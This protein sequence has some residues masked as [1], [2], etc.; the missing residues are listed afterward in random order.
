MM[1]ELLAALVADIQN[2]GWDQITPEQE[3]AC[4]AVI[5]NPSA[6]ATAKDAAKG[7]LILGNLRFIRRYVR[8]YCP[9]GHVNYN[10]TLSDALLGCLHAAE[11]YHPTP[12]RMA[13][14]VSYAHFWMR[15]IILDKIYDPRGAVVPVSLRKL[16][17]GY[18]DFLDDFYDAFHT[19][20]APSDVITALDISSEDYHHLVAASA[21]VVSLSAPLQQ[22]DHLALETLV[23]DEGINPDLHLG[24]LDNQELVRAAL[25]ALPPRLRRILQLR[26]GMIDGRE[27]GLDE[28]GI[29]FGLVRQQISTLLERAMTLIRFEIAQIIS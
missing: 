4:A 8:R 27:L 28:I 11:R 13:R 21:E 23:A 12:E 29:Q 25:R 3:I 1:N 5:Q 15:R 26:Y 22:H 2:A 20:P 24:N 10:D 7:H 9:P 19:E 17:R 16:Q 18:R 6:S 14:F